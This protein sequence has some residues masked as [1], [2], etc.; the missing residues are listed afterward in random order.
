MKL[1]LTALAALALTFTASAEDKKLEVGGNTFTVPAPWTEGQ[2]GMMDKAALNHPVEGGA[3][4]VAKF[5]EFPGAGG[6]VESNV[7]RWQG[8]FEGGKPTE[9]RENLKFGDVEVVLVTLDG[10]YLDGPPMSPNKTPKPDHTML[11]AIII[12]GDI[13]T[14]VKLAGPKAD[15]AKISEGFKKMMLS[16]FPAK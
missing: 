14:F 6:G 4:L 16:P 3:P 2:T 13:G 1:L 10:T 5:Y 8:Q 12:K 9:K 11:G 7:K 15:V